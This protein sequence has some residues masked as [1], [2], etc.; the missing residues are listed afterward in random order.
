VLLAAALRLLLSREAP[1]NVWP[2]ER[3]I[4]IARH[5]FD[6]VVLPMLSRTTGT[7]FDLTEVI[8]KWDLV[9]ASI[10]PLVF[11][12]HAR[13][14]LGDITSAFA[15]AAILT[16]LPNHLHFSRADSEFIQS[17]ATSSLTFV[18]LY[19]ALRDSSPRWRG[20]CFVLLPLLCTAT[21]FVRPENMVFY[22]IDI[23]AILLT[24][25]FGVP[26]VRQ[27][28]AFV[29]VSCAAAFAYVNFLL[30]RYAENIHEGLSVHTLVNAATMVFSPRLN[31]LIN[32]SITPPGLTL[33]AAVGAVCLYRRGLPKRA[34]FLVAWLLGFFVVHSYV[35]PTAPEM[36]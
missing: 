9:L 17:L 6:G 14:V 31:T 24:S 35:R 33:L 16:V 13:Y 1:M 12:A 29:L 20:L 4:P 28:L 25:G 7:S 21:Y 30:V 5:T 11:F 2:Y 10:T 18:V 23:G 34:I 3:I 26:R 32:V 19:T 15:A 22:P 36:Q 27:V 8:F